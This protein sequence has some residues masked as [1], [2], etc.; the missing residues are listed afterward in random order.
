MG[1]NKQ[2]MSLLDE[3]ITQVKVKFS[4]LNKVPHQ[5]DVWGSGS[6]APHILNLGTRW[7]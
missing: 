4:V 6:V 2:C 1:Q 7:N 3:K 5:E